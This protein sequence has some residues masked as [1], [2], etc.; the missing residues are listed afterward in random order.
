M[1]VPPQERERVEGSAGVL[2]VPRAATSARTLA[3]LHL[4]GPLAGVCKHMGMA[5]CSTTRLGNEQDRRA[6]QGGRGV[7]VAAAHMLLAWRGPEGRD[8]EEF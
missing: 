1:R 2:L 4:Q 3:T 7:A 8:A 6:G 5:S